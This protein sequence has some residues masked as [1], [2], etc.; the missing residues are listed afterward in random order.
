MKVTMKNNHKKS[1]HQEVGAKGKVKVTAEVDEAEVDEAEVEADEV[2]EDVA[3][4]VGAVEE[5]VDAVV[6]KWKTSHS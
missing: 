3:G 5:K 2:V 4:E 6:K 1:H